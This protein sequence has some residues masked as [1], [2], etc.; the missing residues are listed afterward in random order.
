MEAGVTAW[1]D[2]EFR[3][4]GLWTEK[5]LP[6]AIQ[7]AK[8]ILLGDGMIGRVGGRIF[9]SLLGVQKHACRV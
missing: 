9:C 3:A 7:I 4:A 8:V 6:P 5:L 2:H 1:P